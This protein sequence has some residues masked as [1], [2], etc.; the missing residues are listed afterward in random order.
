MGKWLDKFSADIQESLPDIPDILPSVSGLSGPYREVSAKI[1]PAPPLQPGWLV[2]Y[3][4]RRGTLC[5]GCDDRAHGTVRACQ[6]QDHGWMVSLTDG[7]SL[8]LSTIRS[9]GQTHE[10][11]QLLAAWTVRE[12]GYDGEGT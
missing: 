8:P 6:W 2:V 9:V 7:Q 3:R 4:D 12:H 11:G 1:T 5:G 10:S